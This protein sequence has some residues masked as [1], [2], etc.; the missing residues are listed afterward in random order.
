MFLICFNEVLL[1]KSTINGVFFLMVL[2]RF[3]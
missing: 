3:Y 2:M 1:R